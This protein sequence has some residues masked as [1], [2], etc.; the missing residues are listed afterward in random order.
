MMEKVRSSKIFK[1]KPFQLPFHVF[2]T[3]WC[4]LY[5]GNF[6][7]LQKNRS[8]GYIYELQH[9]GVCIKENWHLHI[10]MLGRSILANDPATQSQLS[11]H[12]G[13]TLLHAW[14][15]AWC[16]R[17]SSL[18]RGIWR[19]HVDFWHVRFYVQALPEML[20]D[21]HFT[22]IQN[23]NSSGFLSTSF[24]DLDQGCGR[25]AKKAQRY[26]LHITIAP[27]QLKSPVVPQG[28][29]VDGYFSSSKTDQKQSCFKPALSNK[30]YG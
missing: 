22:T 1:L 24:T 15:G 6:D 18:S 25:T 9:G 27:L 8:S 16:S 5:K 13:G 30:R 14:C 10:T 17:C 12:K 29:N 23:I 3:T 11:L 21:S 28:I 4:H 20:S 19:I 7:R 2:E 26:M